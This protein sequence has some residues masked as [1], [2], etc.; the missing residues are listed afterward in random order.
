MS[1]EAAA[2]RQ[3]IL[4][5]LRA[6]RTRR[7]G[8][9]PSPSHPG[10]FLGERP[11]PSEAPSEQFRMLFQSAGG[12]VVALEDEAAAT[13]WIGS[14]AEPGSVCL[15]AGVS[16]AITHLPLADPTVA[17]LGIS[18]A[19][20]AIGET[21]SLVLDSRDGRR[22]QLLVPTHVVLVDARDAHPTLAHALAS[23]Q[24]DL[25]SALG[26]HSGPSKSADIGQVMVRGVHGPGRVVALILGG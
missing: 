10:P 19:R 14:L 6:T 12:E 26:L 3:R 1:P 4:S 8:E 23:L 5:R 18:R 11:H 2:S 15:G 24:S 22:T 25:P 20:A 7:E 21:G 13:R 17:D 9:G 16:R